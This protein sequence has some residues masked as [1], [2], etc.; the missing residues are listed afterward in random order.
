MPLLAGLAVLLVLGLVLWAVLAG[1]GDSRAPQPGPA[2]RTSGGGNT[3]SASSTPQVSQPTPAGMEDF[4]RTYLATVTS[5]PDTAFSMLTPGFQQASGGIGGY[6]GFW[7][8]IRSADVLSFSGANP[9]DLTV[10]YAVDTPVRTAAGP[11]TT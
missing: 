7:D 6:R 1:G 2:H 3:P 5:N 11:A 8:T 10:G 9:D 4:I